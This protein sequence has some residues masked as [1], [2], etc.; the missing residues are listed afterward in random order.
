MTKNFETAARRAA[1]AEIDN[2]VVIEFQING[3][4]LVAQ[5]PT[6][7]Q[8][9]LYSLSQSKGGFDAIEGMFA[10]IAD[11]TGE[12]GVEKVNEALHE[13]VDIPW[14]VEIL[15]YLVG[16]W[17]GRPTKSSKGSSASPKSTGRT[18]T[19]KRPSKAKTS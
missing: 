11:V 5:P 4:D 6:S 2:P 14:V 7:G 9:L 8:L 3:H 13:G 19:A 1:P 10:F 18:S 15:N 12:E 17:T 16:E